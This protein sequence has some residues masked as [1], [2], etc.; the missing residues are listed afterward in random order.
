MK[1]GYVIDN[2]RWEA[3]N[4]RGETYWW[5]Y[6]SEVVD[7]LGLTAEEIQLRDLRDKLP[8]FNL[9]LLGDVD[10]S[11]IAGDL[12]AWV[13]R[14]GHLIASLTSGLDPIIGIEQ[15]ATISQ[16]EGDFS[17]TT[18]MQL[19]PCVPLVQG[20]RFPREQSHPL[21]I[22]S[23]IR[24]FR[25]RV[26]GATTLAFA[27]GQS[28]VATRAFGNGRM[29]YFGFDLAKT[30]WVI[31]QGKPVDADHDGDG[32]LRTGDA[33]VTVDCQPEIPYADELLILVERLIGLSGFPL[34]HRLPPANG[35]IVPDALFF[36]S[37][38]DEG[39]TEVQLESA[40]FMRS[41]GLPYHINC[42]LLNGKYGITSAEIKRL[43]EIGV[44]LAPHFNFVDGFKHPSGFNREDLHSQAK[45][46]RDHFGR[47]PV[48]SNFH[49]CRWT[50]YHEPALWLSEVGIKGDNSY[51]HCPLK[52]L[53][54]VN[55]IGFGFGTAFPFRLYTSGAAGNRAT[56]VIELPI[57]AY[58]VGYT[59]EGTDYS[60][61]E[62]AMQLAV[63]Y[64]HTMN[65]FYH[66][67]YIA[68]NPFCKKAIDH[69]LDC[70]AK[71]GS[72]VVHSTPDR[73]VEWWQ[74][75][76]D[77]SVTKVKQ[78]S[79]KVEF[80]VRTPS[81]SGCIVKV[82]WKGNPPAVSL[83]HRVF[84]EASDSG[85]VMIVVPNGETQVELKYA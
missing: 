62:R 56:G 54:P 25:T 51:I 66:P 38:D 3:L 75:R 41:R 12:Q 43:D 6:I 26:P 20:I 5:A 9:L 14:G 58:E 32:Y 39:A 8:Q 28:I 48:T 79:G 61:L 59:S 77:T 46:F 18:L 27:Q 2:C 45:A 22:A 29:S 16:C 35:N 33:L 64:G 72:I 81:K 84:S 47:T 10:I 85:W 1:A 52:V 83:P 80:L 42:M 78:S 34:V 13:E 71:W 11:G 74:S 76:T 4:R 70:V 67:V 49:W 21:P 65:F 24:L 44:E 60:T 36:Y 37:G 82:R 15:I 31:Q 57:T 40:E 63:H 69:L 53:N 68:K 7:R 73:L 30:F 19:Y 23:E 50:G 55:T 17:I